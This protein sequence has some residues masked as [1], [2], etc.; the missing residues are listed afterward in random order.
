MSR[1]PLR[2]Y[3]IRAR[4]L[5]GDPLVGRLAVAP[6]QGSRSGI[7][8]NPR[9]SPGASPAGAGMRF[10]YD[11]DWAESGVALGAD[12]PLGHGVQHPRL[13][14]TAFGFLE[15]RAINAA[16]FPIFNDP[17]SPLAGLPE[18]TGRLEAAALL[19]P[20]KTDALGALSVTPVDAEPLPERGRVKSQSELPELIYAYHAMERGKAAAGEIALLQKGL[21]LPGRRPVFTV[22]RRSEAQTARLRSMLDPIDRPL[23]MHMAL[24]AARRCGIRTVETELEHEMGENV[25]FTRRADRTGSSADSPFEKPLLTLSGATL[26]RRADSP[27]P[28]SP[29]YLALAD[30]LNA[31]G[32]APAEDL[33]QMWRRIAFGLLT[34]GA[35]DSLQRWQFHREPLGWRLSPAHTLEWNPA[36]QGPGLTMDGRRRL[37]CADDAIPYARYFGLTV[38]DAKGILMEMRRILSGWEGIAEEFGADAR[39]IACMAPLFEENL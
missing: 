3:E 30:I 4:W 29:G 34:G 38:S 20:H 9:L 26:A 6:T 27:R 32:A 28:V 23:W 5:P 35:G 14:K 39:D 10:Q 2:L 17:A 16:V 19:L 7:P 33:P 15:D 18:G 36:A 37:S 21:T 12:L 24:V 22:E 8:Q 13:G 1:P 25:L 31:G 11:G